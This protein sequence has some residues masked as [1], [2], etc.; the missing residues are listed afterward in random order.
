MAKADPSDA[1][2]ASHREAARPTRLRRV[3]RE[4]LAQILT[5][6]RR[7][8]ET[9][10]RQGKRGNLAATDLAGHD[11]SDAVLR[12]L[13][14]DHALLRGANLARADLQR[15]NLAGA[16]LQGACLTGADLGGARRG[17]RTKYYMAT[18]GPNYVRGS[19]LTVWMEG[20]D[21]AWGHSS[22]RNA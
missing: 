3:S 13:K 10:R 15:A 22:N 9:N 2:Q 21:G 19:G 20:K 16:D 12:R 8:L 11:F 18:T 4:E 7:Y 14:L 1:T 6:H 17:S 5:V